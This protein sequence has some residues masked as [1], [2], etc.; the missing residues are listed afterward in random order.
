LP[1]SSLQVGMLVAQVMLCSYDLFL[2]TFSSSMI[3]FA[4][5]QSIATL[6]QTSFLD[7]YPVE[8]I[9]GKKAVRRQDLLSNY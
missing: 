6:H 7:S 8:G 9:G 5:N 4:N 3:V 2:N 1:F